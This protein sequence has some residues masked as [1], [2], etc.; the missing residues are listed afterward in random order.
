MGEPQVYLSIVVP[1]Y[2]E[3]E[4]LDLLHQRLLDVLP[5]LGCSYELIFVDDGSRDDSFKVM[6]RMLEVNPHLRVIRLRRNYGQTAAFSAG[7]DRARG[8]VVIT[9]DADL[10]ND[11]ADI[12]RLLAEFEQG[13]DVV[14]GWRKDRRIAFSTGGCPRS[15]STG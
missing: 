10:Q 13:Y 4:S 3:E 6:K 8:E 9:L 5:G 12:P 11:P 1:V 15:R 2:N 14:S 7:F